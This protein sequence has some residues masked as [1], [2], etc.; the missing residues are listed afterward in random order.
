MSLSEQFQKLHSAKQFEEICVLYDS[1]SV[2]DDELA[3]DW[4]YVYLMNGLYNQKRYSDGLALYKQFVRKFPGND[5]LDSKMGWCVYHLFVKPYDFSVREAEAE[6]RK[7]V[8]YVLKKVKDGK[9][10]PIWKIVQ[11][12]TRGILDRKTKHQADYSQCSWYLE[13]VDRAILSREE[14]VR[15]YDGKKFSSDYENWVSKKTKC[16]LALGA[17]SDCIRLCDEGIRTLPSLHGNNDIWFRA[18][19]SYCLLQMGKTAEAKETAEEILARGVNHW[20]IYELCFDIAVAGNNPQEA[21]KYIGC[22]ALMDSQHQ[23]R[24]NFYIKAAALLQTQ[25]LTRE[26]MLHRRLVV[27]LKQ[28]QEWRIKCEDRQGIDDEVNA[29]GKREVLSALRRFWSK[30]RDQGKIYVFGKITKVFP[31]KRHGWVQDE[32]G[33]EF[34]FRFRDAKGSPDCLQAGVNVL[35]VVGKRMDRKYNKMRETAIEVKLRSR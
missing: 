5:K 11:H 9:Y 6:A 13:Y 34:F 23:M 26:A 15:A 3:L 7:K 19:K 10:S 12:V 28:E 29:M 1:S 4:D 21:M 17:Y 16:L 31:E 25:G 27:L 20:S 18:R 2:E 33:R 24:V 32:T 14:Y 8:E 30:H 22:C 35:F